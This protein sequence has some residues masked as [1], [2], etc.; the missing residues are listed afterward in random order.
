M[1]VEEMNEQIPDTKT[2]YYYVSVVNDR[3]EVRLLL[4]PF[5]NDHSA[6][7]SYVDRCTDA[8]CGLDPKA[9]WY[10]Y[11]TVRLDVADNPPTG[12]FNSRILPKLLD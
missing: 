4:D 10:S 2:G 3:G 9:H 8:A 12:I 7:L 6:A 1:G 5:E 11:G